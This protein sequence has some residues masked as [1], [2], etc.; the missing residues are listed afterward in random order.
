MNAPLPRFVRQIKPVG[1]CSLRC[2]MV[3]APDRIHFGD[4]A[5]NGV[6][7]I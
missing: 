4:M 6:A 7:A 2:R 3:S 5:Q 1:Q